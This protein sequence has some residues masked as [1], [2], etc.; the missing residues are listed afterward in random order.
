MRKGGEEVRE[1]QGTGNGR[2][3]RRDARER[4]GEVRKERRGGRGRE[5]K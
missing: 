4:G 5:E 2:E 3:A 1:G